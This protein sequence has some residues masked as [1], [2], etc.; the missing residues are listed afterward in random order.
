MYVDGVDVEEVGEDFSMVLD[1]VVDGPVP[2]VARRKEVLSDMARQLIQILIVLS[3]HLRASGFAGNMKLLISPQLSVRATQRRGLYEFSNSQSTCQCRPFSS[4]T[5]KLSKHHHKPSDPETESSLSHKIRLLMR[6]IP[7]PVAIVTAYSSSS[8]STT[9]P[10]PR[11]MTVSSF[12][13]V[14]LHPKPIITFNVRQ[15]SETLAALQS[16]GRFLVHLLAP[17]TT[18]ARL[19]RN[20]SRGNVNVELDRFEFIEFDSLKQDS[21][22]SSGDNKTSER[23]LPRLIRRRNNDE[24]KHDTK[25]EEDFTFILECEYLP[26]KSVQ[27][28]D[29]MIVLGNVQRILSPGTTGDTAL[30]QGPEASRHTKE[31]FCLMY[32]DTR[33]WEMGE[34]A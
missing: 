34:E 10:S 28:Y 3:R 29:H 14:T 22:S 11:G 19:A 9:R 6:R 15:P 7:H 16:S 27:V 8:T 20:F 33:F 32:A 30:Q 31:D 24:A 18:M 26:D 17:T 12:N 4:T 21:I 23:I 25:E 5:T 2:D 1:K 13:T